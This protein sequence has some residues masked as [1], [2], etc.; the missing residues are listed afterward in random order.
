M[1]SRNTQ[2]TN[3]PDDQISATDEAELLEGSLTGVPRSAVAFDCLL[4]GHVVALAVDEE[5]VD[6]HSLSGPGVGER[7]V[8][9]VANAHADH[10]DEEREEVESADEEEVV[11]DETV[12]V[13]RK[14][15]SNFRRLFHYEH[16]KQ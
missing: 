11:A 8:E 10:E 12:A 13:R 5:Q 1:P 16:S 6:P 4:E 14:G 3:V 9:P 15:L 7:E 2:K